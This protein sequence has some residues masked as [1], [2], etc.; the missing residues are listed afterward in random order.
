MLLTPELCGQDMSITEE[1]HVFGELP[2]LLCLQ[3]DFT[4]DASVDL[5]NLLVGPGMLFPQLTRLRA[6]WMLL[7]CASFRTTGKSSRRAPSTSLEPLEHLPR[8]ELS[9]TQ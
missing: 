3:Q 9:C 8:D 5:N 4:T 2:E 6:Q 1:F 7:L